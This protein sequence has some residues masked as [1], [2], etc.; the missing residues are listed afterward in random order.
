MY[1][2]QILDGGQTFLHTLG[3]R[4]ATFGAAPGSSVQLRGERIDAQHVRF[5]PIEGGVRLTAIGEVLVNG[6]RVRQVVLQLGDRIEVGDAVLVVGRTVARAAQPEDV[7][8]NAVPRAPRRPPSKKRSNLLPLLGAAA[9]AAVIVG[10]AL[11]GDDRADVRGELAYVETLRASGQLAD[12]RQVMDRLE[13]EWRDATDDRLE[14]LAAQRQA[15]DAVDAASDQLLAQVRD[16]QGDRGYADWMKELQLLEAR[17]SVEQR[18]AARK[19]RSQLKATIQQRDEERRALAAATNADATGESAGSGAQPRVEL[20]GIDTAEIER[21]LGLG[22]FAQAF[23]LVQASFEQATD[24]ASVDALRVLEGTVRDAAARALA[25]VMAEASRR[26]ASDGPGAA[27]AVLQAARDQ[28]PSTQ[29]FRSL[30][31]EID[32]LQ[33]VSAAKASTAV[34]SSKPVTSE[35]PAQP[36]ADAPAVPPPVSEAS[37][38]QTLAAL[39][40]RMDAVRAAEE[41][42]AFAEAARLL[43]EAGEAVRDRDPEFADRLLGRA[44]E[45]ALLASWHGAVRDFVAAGKKVEVSMANGRSAQLLQGEGDA[46]LARTADGDAALLWHE[47]APA[48]LQVLSRQIGAAG[49]AALGA[50]ALLYKQG[51]SAGAEAI[52]ARLLAASPAE[53]SRVDL[54]VARGRGESASDARYVLHKGKLVAARDLDIADR[55]KALSPKLSQALRNRDLAARDTFVS[56]VLAA[57][58]IDVAALGKALWQQLVADR[59][60][61]ATGSLGKQYDKMLAAREELDAARRH[62]KELIYDEARY[63]YPYKPPAVSAEKFAEYNKVQ[64]EVDERVAAVRALWEGNKTKLRVPAELAGQLRDLD[65]LLQKLV[66]LDALPHGESFASALASVGWARG[67]PAGD[68]V[69]LQ[70]FCRD[71]AEAEERQQWRR[72]EAFNAAIA[73][74]LSVAQRELLRHTNEYR[75]IFG[76]RPLAGTPSICAAAQGHADEM[77]KLGYFAHMSPVPEHK[78]PIDRMRKAGYQYGVSENI[79][80]CDGAMAAVGAWRRSSGHHR[81]MLEARHRELG[82]GGNGRYWVQN[83]GTGRDYESHPAWAGTAGK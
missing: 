18:V 68:T 10:F 22:K 57:G 47:V 66:Q 46:L 56:G 21:F 80:L 19:V 29:A 36:G 6:E 14:R 55:V 43:R 8:Q 64:A 52:L 34:A 50:A 67:L 51:D 24:A 30:A 25:G 35:T 41:R 60:K 53:Q 27:L 61:L 9:L 62:A 40:S 44:D 48:G 76:H 69:D 79:A 45:A 17:G 71:R 39:R 63:F 1:T 16:P 82:A 75:A 4:A 70:G 65:W 37:R 42:S 58:G 31:E 12:A 7:L 74:E 28:F 83:F 49:D 33:G 32:R 23:A 20:P 78:T 73:A 38:M 11:G 59:D 3:D 72:V 5:E 77:S 15:V 54:V 26:E 13:R 81:N 2:L